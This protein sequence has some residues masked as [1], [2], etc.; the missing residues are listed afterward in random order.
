MFYPFPESLRSFL[1]ILEKV[2]LPN[3]AF[4]NLIAEHFRETF[5][6][7]MDARLFEN[8]RDFKRDIESSWATENS[9]PLL[10]INRKSVSY[11]C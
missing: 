10:A 3:D 5:Y 9:L 8:P 2:R 7:M 11:F 6:R 4:C 1:E